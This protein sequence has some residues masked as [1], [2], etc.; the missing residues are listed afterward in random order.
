MNLGLLRDRHPDDNRAHQTPAHVQLRVV[1]QNPVRVKHLAA[2]EAGYS[3]AS[4]LCALAP[5]IHSI[6]IANRRWRNI[7]PRGSA[8]H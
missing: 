5:G 7:G 2:T 8:C 3:A 4:E 1:Y 6:E